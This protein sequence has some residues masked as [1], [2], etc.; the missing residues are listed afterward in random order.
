[1]STQAKSGKCPVCYGTGKMNCPACDGKGKILEKV[2]TTDGWVESQ[3][4]RC[5]E[6][7]GSGKVK[8]NY[9]GCKYSKI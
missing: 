3:L 5:N 4:H 7:V 8:C 6:C 1:M 2:E 9:P